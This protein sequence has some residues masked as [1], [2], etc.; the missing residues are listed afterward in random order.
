V[1]VKNRC[2]KNTD[3]A[4]KIMSRLHQKKLNLIIDLELLKKPK[5]I[6]N[7]AALVKKVAEEAR[8]MTT[9]DVI[10]QVRPLPELIEGV[11]GIRSPHPETVCRLYRYF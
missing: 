11:F 3:L 5:S 9:E 8:S 7:L 1:N 2:G 10:F 4:I 6:E